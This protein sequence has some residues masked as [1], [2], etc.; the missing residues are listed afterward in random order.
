MRARSAPTLYSRSEWSRRL[1]RIARAHGSERADW[2]GRKCR[3]ATPRP[4]DSRARAWDFASASP[5]RRGAG[6]APNAQSEP[7][8]VPRSRRGPLRVVRGHGML[9]AK[10]GERCA[11]RRDGA[12][13]TRADLPGGSQ[14]H[15]AADVRGHRD[16]TPVLSFSEVPAILRILPGKKR[17]KSALRSEDGGLCNTCTN[18]GP[19]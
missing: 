11:G 4:P 10:R 8:A 16:P 5:A 6:C 1:L 19:E 12:R 17:K 7:D 3:A 14:A 15:R 2:P 18:S 13:G 9:K